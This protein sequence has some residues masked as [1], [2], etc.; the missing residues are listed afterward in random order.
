MR[1]LGAFEDQKKRFHPG[2]HQQLILRPQR[3]LKLAQFWQSTGTL[4]DACLLME[5]LGL[6]LLHRTPTLEIIPVAKSVHALIFVA[7][8]AHGDNSA[9]TT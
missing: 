5:G 4:S 6:S 9:G 3:L 8:G 2:H 1:G 7:M